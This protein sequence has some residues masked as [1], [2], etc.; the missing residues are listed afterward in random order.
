[1]PRAGGPVVGRSARIDAW[2]LGVLATVVSVAAYLYFRD[3]GTIL[4]YKDSVSHLLIGRR[5]VVGQLTGFGQLGGIWLPLPHL[6][7]GLLAWS[8]TL[9]LSGLAGS[10]FSMAAYVGTVVGLYAVLRVATGDRLAGWVAAAVFGLSADALFLQSTPMGEPIMYFG[11]VMAVLAVLLWYRTGRDRWLLT[12][13]LACLLLVFV[14]Y[15][16]WVFAAALWC[17]VVHICLVKRHR[18]FS[19]DVAGQAYALVF[20]AMMALGVVLWLLWDLVIFGDAFAWLRGSY[21]SID[22]MSSLE[23][24]QVGDLRVSLETYGWGVRETVGLP[25]VACGAAGLLLAAWWERVSPVFTALLATAVPAAFLTYGLWS[26]SQPMRVDQVDGDVYNLRMA[27][28]VLLPVALFTGY[29]VGL[30]RRVPWEDIEVRGLLVGRVLAVGVVLTASGI[31]WVHAWTSDGQSVI[32]SREAGEAYTAYAEQRRVGEF[33]DAETT[34]P[35]LVEAFANEWVVFRAQARVV[36][37]GSQERWRDALLDPG[38]RDADIDVVVMRTTE[39]QTDSVY[40]NLRHSS[41][42]SGF[43]VVLETDNFLVWEKG[44]IGREPGE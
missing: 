6:L 36:Y 18:F 1:M 22:Q 7:I 13:G 39:G 12:G 35:V 17:V 37:E 3:L 20:G 8:D 42:L 5:L 43:G 34:G 33:V 4:G 30:L 21:S 38:S 25:L 44:V 29:A 16:A 31:V 15:E 2:A 26:G 23:L 41:A 9:Y 19:G 28:V 11:I 40:D 24:R 27:V 10:V 32:T 14:R